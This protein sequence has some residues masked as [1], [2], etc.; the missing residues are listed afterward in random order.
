MFSSFDYV[1]FVIGAIGTLN[2]LGAPFGIPQLMVKVLGVL[3]A[4]IC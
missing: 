2:V 4:I 1:A 3:S